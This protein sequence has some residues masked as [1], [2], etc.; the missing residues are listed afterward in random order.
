MISAI[1]NNRSIPDSEHNLDFA[2]N[3][4]LKGRPIQ[5]SRLDGSQWKNHIMWNL[6]IPQDQKS[7]VFYSYYIITS[8]PMFKTI[9]EMQ[10]LVVS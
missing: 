5:D 4:F 2:L 8:R 6:R 1:T 10:T 3:Y 9:T 7:E